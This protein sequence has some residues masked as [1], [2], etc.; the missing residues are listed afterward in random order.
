MMV[1]QPPTIR[2][3]QTYVRVVGRIMQYHMVVYIKIE[4][5]IGLQNDVATYLS[6]KR[7]DKA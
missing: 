6:D 5:V 3:K 1:V 7:F 2:H 4:M